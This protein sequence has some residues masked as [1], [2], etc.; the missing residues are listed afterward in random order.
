MLQV[1]QR[2]AR[3][4]AQL[5]GDHMARPPIG[6]QRVG[7]PVTVIQCGDQLLVVCLVQWVLVGEVAQ[8]ADRLAVPAEDELRLHEHLGALGAQFLQPRRVGVDGRVF[9]QVRQDGAAPHAQRSSQRPG[10]VLVAAVAQMGAGV[11][12]ELAERVQVELVGV[13]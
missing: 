2:R 7:A 1:L 8:H 3:L 11:L 12:H 10:R 4:E 5:G 13:Q 9:L 6:V